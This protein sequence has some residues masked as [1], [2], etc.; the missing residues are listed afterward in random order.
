[1]VLPMINEASRILAEGIVKTPG[2][3]DLGMIMGTGFAPFRGGPLRYAD[4]VGIGRIVDSLQRLSRARERQFIPCEH[5]I[6]MSA[7]GRTF[8]GD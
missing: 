2:D 8:H 6:E 7:Q 1:M 5:L 4:T 3:V